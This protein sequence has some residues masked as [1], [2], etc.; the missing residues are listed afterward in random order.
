M[1]LAIEAYLDPC[2]KCCEEDAALQLG[3]IV[4]EFVSVPEADV[5]FPVAPVF[6]A[7]FG[8]HQCCAIVNGSPSRQDIPCEAH[9]L[10]SIISFSLPGMLRGVSE[11]VLEL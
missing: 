6:L 8:S 4:Q 2:S 7:C 10:M 5:L 9:E 3:G 11:D 1:S